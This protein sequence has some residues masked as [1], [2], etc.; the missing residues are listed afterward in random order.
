VRCFADYDYQ[1]L[2]WFLFLCFVMGNYK[3]FIYEDWVYS[4]TNS[5]SG[6]GDLIVILS[7]RY[8]F[9][10][11]CAY[12]VCIYVISFIVLIQGKSVIDL[13]LNSRIRSC[14]R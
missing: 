9:W 11:N 1:N 2:S 10:L 13:G 3:W 8:K 7:M 4:F 12:C 14:G 6:Y 5:S